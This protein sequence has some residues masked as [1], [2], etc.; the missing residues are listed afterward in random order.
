MPKITCTSEAN[1]IP[2]SVEFQGHTLL[3][4]GCVFHPKGRI[5]DCSPVTHPDGD[6]GPHPCLTHNAVL[7][8]ATSVKVNA[9]DTLPCWVTYHLPSCTCSLSFPTIFCFLLAELAQAWPCP[10]LARFQ[11]VFTGVVWSLVQSDLPWP[12]QLA[13]PEHGDC[14]MSPQRVFEDGE[15]NIF[16]QIPSCCPPVFAEILGI[17]HPMWLKSYKEGGFAFCFLKPAVRPF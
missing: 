15:N 12:H 13:T 17:F 7:G 5:W 4:F 3:G 10:A 14:R 16:S 6:T 2:L 1:V 8:C 9:P 11:C